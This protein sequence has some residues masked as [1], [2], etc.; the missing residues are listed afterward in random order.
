[1][2]GWHEFGTKE[3]IRLTFNSSIEI[4]PEV[5]MCFTGAAAN[6]DVSE[7]V[8]MLEEGVPID[9][10]DE[11]GFTALGNAVYN[12]QT[13]VIPVL[14]QRRPDVNQRGGGGLTALH[15]SAVLNRTHITRALLEHGASTTIKDD[16]G[17]TPIDLARQMNHTEAVLLLQH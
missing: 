15:V 1:M 11:N 10:V 9:I 16:R 5:V 8:R 14:L 13:A 17:Q 12:N 4:N 6:D 3:T 2:N 7:V